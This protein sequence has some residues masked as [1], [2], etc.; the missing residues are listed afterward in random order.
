MKICILGAG[1]TGLT[2][3]RL[4]DPEHHDVQVLEKSSVAGGLCRSSVVEGFTCDHSGG[5]ILFSKDKKTLDWMLDQVGR[6]NI[7]KKDRHTRIRWHDRYVPYP[8]ENGVG[9]L[10]PEAKFDCLKGYLEA[11]EQRKAEPCPENFHDWI[12]WKMGRGFADHF[13]F[14]YNRKIW[15]C[16]LH[17]MSSGWVAGRVPDAPVDD[18]LKAACGVNTEGYTHQALFYFPLRGGFQAL[19]DGVRRGVQHPIHMQ[20]PV[21]SVRKTA[22]GW[23]VNDVDFDLVVNTIALPEL[24]PRFEGLPTDVAA[25]IAALEPVS[26]VNVLVGM[27]A[28]KPLQDLSWIY[29]PFEDQ[30][31]TNRLTFFSNY[32]PLNAPEGHTSYMAEATYR[33]NLDVSQDWID[34]LVSGLEHAGVLRR[35]DVTV[36]EH[37]KSRYAYIDQNIEFPARIQRVR[38]WFDASGMLTVGRFGRYEYHNSDQCIM[39]AFEAVKQIETLSQSGIVEPFVFS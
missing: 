24:A 27:K 20:T 37:W 18:I 19:T 31:V 33:G 7:V 11:V 8:F 1:I 30:G 9:H 17:E 15:G 22:D 4:L 13:M 28:D 34:Q 25:D 32:S 39:R 21:E 38:E 6:D 29:L 16:D 10:T 26:L 2:V 36:T 3:A 23:R 5:H 35:S 14:P 12:V